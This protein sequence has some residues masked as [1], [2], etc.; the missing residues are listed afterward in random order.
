MYA[1]CVEWFDRKT[2]KATPD[3]AAHI[4]PAS[5]R[6]PPPKR[7]SERSTSEARKCWRGN[8]FR[9]GE[10][11]VRGHVGA[12]SKPDAHLIFHRRVGPMAVQT[13]CRFCI[14]SYRATPPF[15]RDRCHR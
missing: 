13:V 3:L 14:R 11:D 4:S 10:S 2:A 9:A 8:L 5:C 1:Q 6:P 12:K 7:S 15:G